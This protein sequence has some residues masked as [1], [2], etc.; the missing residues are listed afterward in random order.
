M[1]QDIIIAIDGHSAC[2]K[3]TLAKDLAK[4]IGYRHIDS[5]A[6]YRAVTLHFIEQKVDIKNRLEIEEA[7]QTLDL[8]LKVTNEGKTDIY[9][10]QNP[11]DQALRSSL[12]N[13]LVSEI[14]T[15]VPVRKKLVHLQQQL[16]RN[17]RIVMDGRD[18]GSVV[19]PNAKLK[20]FL[21]ASVEKRVQRRLSEMLQ[22][23]MTITSLEV[24]D[25]LKH[26]DMVDSTRAESPLLQTK[27]AVV[28]DNT[29]L[30]R[31]EQL[32][33]VLALAKIRIESCAK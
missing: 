14:S 1:A 24:E 21:T 6:M 33:M 7:V 32:A 9:L 29:N 12:V 2:G 16:G 19:F 5:G 20:I 15:L 10:N 8:S 18:I 17:Q 30:S 27:D 23:Q 13:G 22:K 26:R 25:N 28:I 31:Q 3:S 4:E 11:V